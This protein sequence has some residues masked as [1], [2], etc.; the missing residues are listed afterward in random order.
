LDEWNG[1]NL[2]EVQNFNSWVLD[3]IEKSPDR[4]NPKTGGKISFRTIQEYKTTYKY[5]LEFQ[6]ENRVKIDFGNIDVNTLIDF[7]DYL[8]TVKEFSVNNIAK[9]IDNVRQF[10]RAATAAKI[11]IDID[12]INPSMLRVARENAKSI[13]LNEK[14]LELIYNIDLSHKPT[15]DRVR[16]LFAIGCNTGLRISDYNNIQPHNIKGDTLHIIQ[17]KTGD[18]VYIPIHKIVS[19]IFAKYKGIAPPKISD[20][21]LNKYIKDVCSMAGIVD[22]I[23]VQKTKAGERTKNVLHKWQLVTSHTARRSFASNL[24]KRGVPVHIIMAMTGHKK[25]SVFLKYVKISPMEYGEMLRE[26][27]SKTNVKTA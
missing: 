11:E 27:M 20:Q 16:D 2:K 6:N 4:I 25:E 8:T 9:H 15:H 26:Y 3:Y 18:P 21:K 5:L 10:L 22:K 23:E 7:R 24:I 1:Y 12:T 19:E 13:Y 17:Q 14:E